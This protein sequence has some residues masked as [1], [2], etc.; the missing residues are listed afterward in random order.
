V[1]VVTG[2]NVQDNWQIAQMGDFEFGVRWRIKHSDGQWFLH[3]HPYPLAV[4]GRSGCFEVT[5][6]RDHNDDDFW[7]ILPATEIQIA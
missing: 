4:S 3:S 2:S 5:C 7:I 6:C 1:T